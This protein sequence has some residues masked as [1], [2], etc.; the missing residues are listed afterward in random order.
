M[1]CFIG[2]SVSKLRFPILGK[3]IQLLQRNK[4][5]HTWIAFYLRSSQKWLVIDATSSGVK[6]H[7]MENF[8]K[9]HKMVKKYVIEATEDQKRAMLLY[10]INQS[11]TKYSII[12]LLGNVV[13]M[14]FGLK[15]NPVGQGKRFTRC[16]ELVGEILKEVFHH[17]IPISLDNTDLLWLDEYLKRKLL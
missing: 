2:F 3:L 11:Y 12:E 9:H 4:F 6:I 5:S 14:I 16:N 13:Q 17:D 10:A 15:N 7:D 8:K 1:E